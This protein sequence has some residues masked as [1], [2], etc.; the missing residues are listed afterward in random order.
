MGGFF[1]VKVYPADR[2][3]GPRINRYSRQGAPTGRRTV[4]VVFHFG[5]V[6]ISVGKWLP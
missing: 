4:G 1:C 2:A 6:G 3:W 5:S